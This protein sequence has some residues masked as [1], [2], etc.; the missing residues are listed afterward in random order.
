[1]PYRDSACQTCSF[2]AKRRRKWNSER[3]MDCGASL[4]SVRYML[5]SLGDTDNHK[6]LVMRRQGKPNQ[7]GRGGA[8]TVYKRLIQAG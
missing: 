1:M 6:A 5:V 3:P 7:I 4:P 8:R 2:L